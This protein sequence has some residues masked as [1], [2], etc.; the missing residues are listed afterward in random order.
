MRMRQE[1]DG[2]GKEKRERESR[3]IQREENG[4]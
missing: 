1:V 3:R 4:Q 2:N